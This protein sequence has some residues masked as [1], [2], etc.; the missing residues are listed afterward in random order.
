MPMGSCK[1][2]EGLSRRSKNNNIDY[3]IIHRENGDENLTLKSVT[4]LLQSKN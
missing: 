4:L 1:S 3:E 2:S